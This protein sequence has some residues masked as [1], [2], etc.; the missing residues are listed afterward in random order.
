M[1]D[2][3]RGTSLQGRQGAAPP[4]TGQRRG[5]TSRDRRPH[6][7]EAD[8]ESE[9]DQ[10]TT[11]HVREHEPAPLV[12]ADA[13]SEPSAEDAPLDEGPVHRP[14]IRATLPRPEGIKTERPLPEF[15]IRQN[16]TRGNGNNFRGGFAA[17]GRGAQGMGGR[18]GGNGARFGR[19][20][21]GRGGQGRGGQ[22]AGGFNR[23]PK[24][25]SR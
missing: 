7:A 19:G 18:G 9:P 13:L 16:A 23:G 4:Q 1:L 12:H 20:P 14:L 21:Q 24:K 22:S 17:K 25:R 5:R 6:P 11:E 2:V 8:P 10:P 3:R 15:T